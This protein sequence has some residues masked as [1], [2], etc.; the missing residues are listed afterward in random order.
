MKLDV[1]Y[2]T[3]T[4]K[5]SINN[6]IYTVKKVTMSKNINIDKILQKIG[7]SKNEQKS[8]MLQN[9]NS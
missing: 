3:K 5:W 6:K 1:K 8:R 2:A 4:M 7:K 9:I